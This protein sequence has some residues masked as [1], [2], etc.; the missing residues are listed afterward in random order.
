MLLISMAV[1]AASGWGLALHW[2][3]KLYIPAKSNGV[4][5]VVA[6]AEPYFQPWKDS[7][8]RQPP[9]PLWFLRHCNSVSLLISYMSHALKN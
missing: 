7:R 8:G 1:E 4:T 2:Y 6:A 9:L 5:S 3:D